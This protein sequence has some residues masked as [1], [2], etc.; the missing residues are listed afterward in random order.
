MSNTILTIQFLTFI[1][2]FLLGTFVLHKN[3]RS[4]VFWF[5]WVMATGIAGWNLSLFFA[6][7][8][9]GQSLFWGRL[10]FSFGALM[11]LGLYLFSISFPEKERLFWAKASAVVM[12]GVF[13]FVVSLTGAF[14]KSVQVVDRLYLTGSLTPVILFYVLYDIY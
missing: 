6:I 9:L 5:F 3:P 12:P 2:N 10:A 14:I 13:F 8:G 1:I 11:P 7:S 4:P